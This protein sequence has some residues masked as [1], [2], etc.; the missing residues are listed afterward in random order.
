MFSGKMCRYNPSLKWI[1]KI[2]ITANSFVPIIKIIYDEYRRTEI[3][4]I[5][6]QSIIQIIGGTDVIPH[7]KFK[8]SIKT[9][10]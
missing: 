10:I 5:I 9:T 1:N 6:Y 4:S 7:A 3:I 2:R 8:L